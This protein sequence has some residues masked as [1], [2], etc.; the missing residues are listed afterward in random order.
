LVLTKLCLISLIAYTSRNIL[1]TNRSE[2]T[3]W[4]HG[5]CN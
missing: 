3:R 2:A 4:P 1:A 5:N